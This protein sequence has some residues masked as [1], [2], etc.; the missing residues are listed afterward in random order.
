MFKCARKKLYWELL[1]TTTT[2]LKY[3]KSE[4]NKVGDRYT[5]KKMRIK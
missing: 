3:T 1:K 5:T 2:L 4:T